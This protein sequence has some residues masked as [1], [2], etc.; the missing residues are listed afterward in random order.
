MDDNIR[1]E[2]WTLDDGRRAE[3]RVKEGNGGE[4]VVE[5]FVEDE[6]PL[7][8]KQRVVEK[9]KPF[10]FERHIQ[11]LDAEGNVI[12]QKVESIEPKVQLQ[13]VE[14]LGV[15]GNV[16]A[17]SS[18][19]D[20]DCDC[21]VTKEE[22]IETVVAAIKAAKVANGDSA[23]VRVKAQ[24]VGLQSQGLA[25]EIKERVEKKDYSLMDKVLI[26][27]ILAQVIGLGYVIF[28]M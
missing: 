12:E 4:K 27:V 20:E 28:A 17:Q 3:R 14:H 23:P 13:L 24:S 8:L 22:M 16:T 25:D 19:K 10:V 21:H 7:R 9:S 6:R 11:D 15:A 1:V 26:G 18:S 2:K 5:Y